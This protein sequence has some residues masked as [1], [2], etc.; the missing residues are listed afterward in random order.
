MKVKVFM[1]DVE[2][3]DNPI[4]FAEYDAEAKSQI[5]SRKEVLEDIEYHYKYKEESNGNV[6]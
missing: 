5:P 6:D 1:Y 3:E 4:L 2:D